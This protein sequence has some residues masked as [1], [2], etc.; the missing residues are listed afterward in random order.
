MSSCHGD[1]V[2]KQ[3]LNFVTTRGYYQFVSFPTRKENILRFDF[4][5]WWANY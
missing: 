2:S 5:K 1:G 4:C 3:F